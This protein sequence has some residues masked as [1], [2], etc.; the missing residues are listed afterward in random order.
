MTVNETIMTALES[1]GDPVQY[2]EYIPPNGKAYPDK[3]YT[4]NYSIIGADYGDDSPVHERYLVQVHLY[5]LRTYDSLERV[6]R[7]Q[8]R[9]VEAG[10]TR[11][12]V[13]LSFDEDG[14]HIVFEC[15]IAAGVDDG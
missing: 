1:F 14:Q 3:Y 5:C 7:T 10:F 15:E 9:L 11:P 4:F 12:S 2:G 8:H 6:K 13:M